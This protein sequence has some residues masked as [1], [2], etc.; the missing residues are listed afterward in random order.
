MT[1]YPEAFIAEWLL[2]QFNTSI[3]PPK[4]DAKYY[5]LV[6]EGIL[7]GYSETN[8]EESYKTALT[9]SNNFT[10]DADRDAQGYF[11]ARPKD[12]SYTLKF[13]YLAADKSFVIMVTAPKG[14]NN[15]AINAIFAA[16]NVTPFSLA[17]IDNPNISFSASEMDTAG[18]TYA[19]ITVGGVSVQEVQT[20]VN[21]LKAL[22]YKV[23]LPNVVVESNQY[24]TTVNV[25]TNEGMFTVYF[26]YST[27]Q[28]ANTLLIYLNLT[29]NQYVVKDWPAASIARYLDA[30]HDTVPAFAGDA[31]GFNFSITNT[32]NNVAVIVDNGSE[33]AA[34]DS[35]IKTLTIDNGYTA[36]GTLGGQPAYKSPNE[37][38]LVAIGCDPNTFPGEINILIQE[39]VKVDTRW[40]T[41]DV[42][43]AVSKLY[44]ED[45]I[46]DALPFLDVSDASYC[47]V[48]GTSGE[49]QI[50]IDIDGLASSLT[51]FVGAYKLDGWTEDPYYPFN[52]TSDI[53]GALVSPNH[54]LVASFITVN[55]DLVLYVQAYRDIN[56]YDWPSTELST[57]INKWGVKKDVLPSFDHAT[58]VDY[59][60]N[61]SSQNVSILIYLGSSLKQRVLTEYCV[62]LERMGYH[63]EEELGGFISN[64]HE[65]F[66]KVS[67]DDNGIRVTVSCVIP[68]YKVVGTF[69]DWSFESAP[70]LVDATDPQD[71]N[72]D[73]QYS[74][75][76][77]VNS[78]NKF[79]VLDD[80]NNWYGCKDMEVAYDSKNNDIFSQ[81]DNGDIQVNA[82]G[83]VTL[84][85]KIKNGQKSMW[86]EFAADPVAP[87]WP[88]DSINGALQSWGVEDA[89]PTLEDASISDVQYADI[90]EK[91]FA[92]T[93][94]GGASLID[95]YNASLGEY[96][97]D[98]GG[99]VSSSGKLVIKTHA[100]ADQLIIVVE[101]LEE[102]PVINP[103]PEEEIAQ[104]F[105]EDTFTYLPIYPIN[106]ATY[107]VG[108]TGESNGIKFMVINVTGQN[109][110]DA[111][112][113]YI[114]FLIDEKGY[115]GNPTYPQMYTSSNEGYPSV[116]FGG[117]NSD[118]NSFSITLY[119]LPEP[120]PVAWPQDS[121]DA[122]MVN[123]WHVDD[124]VPSI[125]DE[126][127]TAINVVPNDENSFAI[128]LVGGAGLYDRYGELMEANYVYDNGEDFWVSNSGK[129]NV[130]VSAT[131]D[132]LIVEVGLA[133]EAPVEETVYKLVGEYNDW[134]YEYGD[135]LEE[136][137][138]KEGYLKQY[139]TSFGANAGEVFK[140]TDGTLWYGF[141]ALQ[142]NAYFVSG[143]NGNII[144]KQS[145]SI[146]LEFNILANGDKEII[147]DF[148]PL[149]GFITWA[150]AKESL[151]SGLPEGKV[152]PNLEVDGALSYLYDG[153]INIFFANDADMNAMLSAVCVKLEEAEYHYSRR[154]MGFV[155]TTTGLCFRVEINDN[156][157][158]VSCSEQTYEN[159]T[160][161]GVLIL[162]YDEASDSYVLVSDS[163][164]GQVN[165]SNDKEYFVTVEFEAGTMFVVY[166]YS[167]ETEFK[168]NIDPASLN[169]QFAD[170]FEY[171]A[172]RNAYVVKQD[173]TGVVYI[174][175]NPGNDEIYIGFPQP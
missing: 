58:F 113:D 159:D 125:Q 35:Y 111:V 143:N 173:F 153:S 80:S 41:D 128:T 117:D 151:E 86:L 19:Y 99:Y 8:L 75:S 170:Y 26:T 118:K 59:L 144:C 37:E 83:T 131:E 114:Q 88:T 90:N 11:V 14:W 49:Y 109:V 66:V 23:A 169:G 47:G 53:Y 122:I 172:D 156:A 89:I 139:H 175:L 140:I 54:Q 136:L 82:A 85:L 166:D 158:S 146:E 13:Q 106:G 174:K 46:T 160:G 165:P 95:Q 36:S 15:G 110:D 51:E 73:I 24:F 27:A 39:I 92:L 97:S 132:D 6:S 52:T 120:E 38:I 103:W 135:E 5:C 84:Y 142:E 7:Y 133:G 78:A 18:Q 16:N 9:S 63:Y 48:N 32:Y 62:A 40:P 2:K 94:T 17:S 4:F 57:I 123:Q 42:A 30:E 56:Y 98:K 22:G 119:L 127:I 126:S 55:N 171:D 87:A 76:F 67:T 157:I 162:S 152:V 105:G 116:S 96:N 129:I 65:L 21:A 3:N 141:E 79:K 163:Y 130:N 145:G 20:Y 115:A 147:I 101:L 137:E 148:T 70:R 100:N 91:S 102:E 10:V 104:F 107:S 68:V 150:E 50:E 93:I 72:Y 71:E 121:I 74:A 43:G 64:Y 45:P 28:N 81:L 149:E 164:C 155:N 167:S 12:G 33:A 161:Y 124:V 112:G 44:S 69:N 138:A 168:V 77:H 134:D 154:F 1:D 108:N 34:R 60:E 31:Y 25:I 29:P 61:T